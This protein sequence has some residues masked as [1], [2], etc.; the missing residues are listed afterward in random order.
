LIVPGSDITVQAHGLLTATTALSIT[1]GARA[2]QMLASWA[3]GNDRNGD[4]ENA[5]SFMS[6]MT[7]FSSA[8]LMK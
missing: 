7:A 5:D 6:A 8:I 4:Q 3:I 1:V 2:T